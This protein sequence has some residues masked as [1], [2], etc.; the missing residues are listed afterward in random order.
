MAIGLPTSPSLPRH[1]NDMNRII[2][3]NSHRGYSRSIN[4][5]IKNDILKGDVVYEEN[6]FISVFKYKRNDNQE[7]DLTECATGIK[8]VALLQ[9]LLKNRFLDE[10]T[11]LIIDEPEAHLHPQWIIEYARVLVLL[12]KKLK[13]KFFITSHSTDMVSAI[14]YISEKSE[15]VK[16]YLFMLQMKRKTISMFI[17]T[18]G[19]I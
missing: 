19:M 6:D 2:R 16:M 12:H 7:F 14:K 3:D 9:L 13:V 15:L 5:L 1:W 8:S 11:L 10:N 18:W 4:N 17:N